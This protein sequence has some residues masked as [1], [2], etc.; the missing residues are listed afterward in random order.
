VPPQ[1]Q[2]GEITQF[3]WQKITKNQESLQHLLQMPIDEMYCMPL[4]F[5]LW[6]CGSLTWL[7]RVL[8]RLLR[9][10]MDGAHDA[11]WKISE[12]QRVIDVVRY[13]TSVDAMSK[14][15]EG[16]YGSLGDQ[17]DDRSEL[18]R[19]LHHIRMLR[20]S[21]HWHVQRITGANMVETNM[22]EQASH[23]TGQVWDGDSELLPINFDVGGGMDF[24]DVGTW[25]SINDFSFLD[26]GLR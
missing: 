25:T 13:L 10:I 16:A 14:K 8:G 23:L 9:E 3:L 20:R 12:A 15:L 6:L 19:L 4:L 1:K 11:A 17:M 21:Y 7:G 18:G 26:E 22:L 5:N 24:V 2:T